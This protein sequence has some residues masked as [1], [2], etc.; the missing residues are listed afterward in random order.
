MAFAD[1]TH[2]ARTGRKNVSRSRE[3]M[4]GAAIL[5]ASLIA[6]LGFRRLVPAEAV[7]P[8][9]VT[10]LFAGS[11]V[12]AGLALLCRR[13]RSRIMWLDLAGGLTFVGIVISVFIEPDQLTR[14]VS[15]SDQPE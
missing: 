9:M 4:A 12:A 3:L 14:L 2:I 8:M 11:A 15:V 6:T 5:L 10:L 7:A 1:R 13:H